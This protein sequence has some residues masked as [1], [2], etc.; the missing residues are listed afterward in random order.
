MLDTKQHL[1]MIVRYQ[2]KRMCYN[3]GYTIDPKKWNKDTQ[4]CK[5][6][7]THGKECVPAV[8]I[9][10]VIQQY[11]DK[12]TDIF[13]SHNATLPFQTIKQEIDKSLN[14]E[15]KEA[16]EH[17][18]FSF[19]DKFMEEERIHSNWTRPMFVKMR[20]IKKHIYEF[21]KEMSF[22]KICLE[23][24]D[25]YCAFLISLNFRSSYVKK[26]IETTKVFFKWAN[27]RG[28]I[29]DT[30]F[31]A[32]RCKIK[33]V[34]K[35]VIFLTWDELMKVYNFNFGKK[36]YLSKVRDAF[37]FSCFTS[38][39]YSDVRKLKK[40]D[41]T[42]GIIHVTTQKT[43]DSLNIELNKYSSAILQKYK[44][45]ESDYALPVISN[46]KM[47]IYLKEMGET[48]GIDELI[49]E[50]FY[51]GG[52]RREKTSYKW[53]LLT[54]HCGRRTFICNAL[55]MGIPPIIVM[56]WTGHSDY[57]SMQ[58]YIDT[59]DSAKRNAISLFNR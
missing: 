7:T 48:C 5:R 13:N 40:D 17:G 52:K 21:D 34:Q 11:E 29:K 20:T 1:R 30:T 35:R 26:I 14:R 54:T 18:F 4:R 12:V 19:Y 33:D 59:A 23:W 58:P 22:D 31:N 51:Q 8:K 39:R 16:N 37:C 49:T 28:Y 36:Y 53:L 45:T 27:G 47:N 6:N 38:L 9:N 50:T 15:K 25:N 24:F 56:K 41:I 3:V 43:S 2:G 32:Y 10:A 44:N 55:T 42:D 57:K 46:V